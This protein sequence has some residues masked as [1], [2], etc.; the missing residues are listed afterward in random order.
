V[1]PDYNDMLSA[2]LNAGAEFLV[3]GAYAMA[4]HGFPRATGDIDIWVRPTPENA[5]RVWAG[6]SAFGA[7]TSKM[8]LSDFVIP[9]IVYQIGVAPR[10]IDLLTS[11]TGVAF[12]DAWMNRIAVQMGGLLIPVIGRD[13]LLANKRSTGRIKDLA[14]VQMIEGAQGEQ[15]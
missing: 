15:S 10:R 6:L 11:I 1:N 5:A 8:Q 14:D 4:A 13:E 9:D 12:E 7:P 2:L 3:V